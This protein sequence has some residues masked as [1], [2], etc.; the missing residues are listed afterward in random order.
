MKRRSFLKKTV[1]GLG[2]LGLPEVGSDFYRN[3]FGKSTSNAAGSSLGKAKSVIQVWMWG[4]PS[5]LETFD[6][7]PDA[8]RNFCGDWNKPIK[9]NVPGIEL[10]Q[11][12]PQL[13]QT[14]DLFAPIRSMTHDTNHHETACYLMQTGR[15]PGGGLVYPNLAAVIS[16][17]NGYDAGYNAPIPP[18]VVLTTAQGRFS[19]SGFLGPRYKPFVTG[20]DP[21]KTPFLVSGF[22]AEGITP[23]RQKK[24]R[25]LSADLD[26]LD[27]SAKDIPLYDKIDQLRDNSWK[28]LDSNDIKAFDLTTEPEKIREAYGMNWFGQSCLM[29]RRLVEKEV[30]YITINYRGWDTHRKHFETLT[31]RQGEWDQGLSFLLK[32]L[33][34][35]NLLDQTVIW[36]SGEFGRTPLI[37][38]DAPWFGGRGHYCRCFSAMVA[39]GGF[40]GGSVIGKS[41]PTGEYVAERPVAPQ[42]LLGSIFNRVGINPNDKLK[43]SKGFDLPIMPPA[44]EAGLLTELFV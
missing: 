25:E 32:D 1:I 28:L 22:V 20:G 3:A 2:L 6:P 29:A 24:R 19:E 31:R 21:S 18:Y 36:W 12:L 37:G 16:K 30:P 27:N 34:D 23:E 5:H 4:G 39:G 7:K 8:G 13:A 35:H 17:M 33:R 26:L 11:S 41:T 38:W 42:D 10:S 43:N 9:S 44:S 14:A 40:K 15:M